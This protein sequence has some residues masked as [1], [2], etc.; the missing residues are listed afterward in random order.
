MARWLTISIL[1]LLTLLPALTLFH[2]DELGHWTF[3]RCAMSAP[4]EH[5]Y[6][7]MAQ[8][9]ATGHGPSIQRQA[10]SETF[11]PPGFPLLLAAWSHI[12][13]PLAN[14]MG[15]NG[16][17]SRPLTIE[18]AHA[19]VAALLAASI[20][21]VF[22]LT[23]R[24]LVKPAVSSGA[25]QGTSGYIRFIQL[26]A[27]P[28]SS[29]LN[30]Q[31]L[32]ALF[33]TALYA[34]N[35]YVLDTAL[36]VFSEPA[37]ILFTLLWLY[38][39]V[40]W[41]RWY[42]SPRLS[43]LL[44][45][46]AAATMSMRGAGIVCAAATLLYPFFCLLDIRRSPAPRR[47]ISSWLCAAAAILAYV[48]LAHWLMPK[49]DGAYST[50]LIRGISDQF[51]AAIRKQG[52]SIGILIDWANHLGRLALS[53]L[54]DWT[55]NFVPPYRESEVSLLGL[56]RPTLFQ[57]IAN[58][59]LLLA[60]CGWL[61]RLCAPLRTSS[62]RGNLPKLSS[63][64]LHSTETR[65]PA[66]YIFLYVAL[67]L[68]WP[69]KMVRFWIPIYPLMLAYA[70]LAIQDAARALGTSAPQTTGATK[71]CHAQWAR[72]EGSGHVT[73]RLDPRNMSNPP[74]RNPGT[75]CLPILPSPE[76]R[77]SVFAALLALLLLI[78]FTEELVL[79]FPYRQRRL[80]YVSDIL[81]DTAAYLNA[82]ADPKSPPVLVVLGGDEAKMMT[83]YLGP[84]SPLVPPLTGLAGPRA[85]VQ[86][87]P[88]PRIYFMGYFTPKLGTEIL[89]N[90]SHDD[91]HFAPVS[92][93]TISDPSGSS[94]RWHARQCYQRWNISAL[95]E[96]EPA[97]PPA[98]KTLKN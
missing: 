32:P 98:K 3:N 29:D 40:R 75:F 27:V 94:D 28:D 59:L 14:L 38:V 58:L 34:A 33:I 26:S 73:Q 57:L 4:D 76:K 52:L 39:A 80:N 24:L 48:L 42:E 23:R 13:N 71:G 31:N 66:F 95:W 30:D 37:F 51:P 6:L 97:P 78:L 65:L 62:P 49:S 45:A 46:L 54:A 10:G 18:S 5:S 63:V 8:N 88:T 82:H 90:L 77:H 92:A 84:N 41:P 17:G 91:P 2:Q 43:L 67:Y 56:D 50:Q 74:A 79:K 61:C 60:L 47:L 81:A 64:P 19:C 83:W 53:H 11:Y 87:R 20:P 96:L 68:L 21:L 35:W 25:G 9:F 55:A 70:W 12:T 7:L 44:G 72:G 36:F 22:L 16:G 85:I 1:A 89:T 93:S 69:F 15:W 86:Q